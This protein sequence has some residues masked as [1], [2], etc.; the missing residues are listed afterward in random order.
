MKNPQIVP[1]QSYK[2]KCFIAKVL[3]M[4]KLCI[5]LLD[6]NVMAHTFCLLNSHRTELYSKTGNRLT[7]LA[8]NEYVNG[9]DTCVLWICTFAGPS[10]LMEYNAN[11]KCFAMRLFRLSHNV[12][13]VTR[14]ISFAYCR[15]TY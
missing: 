3:A 1:F 9:R 13:L 7:T 14:R 2:T 15:C 12:V 8:L 11:I 5:R 6:L 10:S 4:F